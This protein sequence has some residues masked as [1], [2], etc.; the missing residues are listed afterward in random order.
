MKKNLFI[1]LLLVTG[2]TPGIIFGQQQKQ[3][4]VV[5][6]MLLPAMVTETSKTETVNPAEISNR[7]KTGMPVHLQDVSLPSD[8]TIRVEKNGAL[9]IGKKQLVHLSETGRQP[10]RPREK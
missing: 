7:E 2:G 8:G 3:D 4:L 9:R 6:K 10:V 5:N 1:A